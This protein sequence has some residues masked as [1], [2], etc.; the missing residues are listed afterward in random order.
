MITTHLIVAGV[1]FKEVGILNIKNFHPNIYIGIV[2]IVLS[3]FFY[4]MANQFV[5][6]AAAIWPKGVLICIIALS[7]LLIAQGIT[8]TAKRND[9]KASN[10]FK[11]ILVPLLTIVLIAIYAILMNFIGFFASTAFFCPLGMFALGQRNWKAIIGVTLGLDVF[12]YVL[13]VTQL[14]LQMP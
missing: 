12:V 11:S 14:Q 1:S 5:N 3:G 6:Q 2:L 8:L 10:N 4:N 13:F 9:N 7:A